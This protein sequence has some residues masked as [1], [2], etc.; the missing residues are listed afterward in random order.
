MIVMRLLFI[1]GVLLFFGG[2][3]VVCMLLFHFAN[4]E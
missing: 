4:K 2:G 3:I 1:L